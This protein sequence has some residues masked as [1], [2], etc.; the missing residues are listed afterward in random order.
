[1]LAKFLSPGDCDILPASGAE[2]LQEILLPPVQKA[3]SRSR[4]SVGAQE[5]SCELQGLQV[6]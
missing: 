3:V 4:M 2:L 5:Q 1:M 6:L